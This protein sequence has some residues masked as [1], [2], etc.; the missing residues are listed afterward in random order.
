MR[1]ERELERYERL[2]DPA[3]VLA[4]SG[5]FAIILTL[6]VLEIHVPDLARGQS[7][8]EAIAEVRPSFVAFLISFVVVAISW[9]GHRDLFAHIRRTDRNLVWLNVV[10]LLPLSLLPFG[11]ALLSQYQQEAVALRMYG[12]LLLLIALTRLVVWLYAV[13]RPHL[14]H[15]AISQRTRTAG[16]IIAGVPAVY[17]V[18]ILLA[19]GSPEASLAIYAGAPILYFI[20]LFLERSTAPPGSEENDFT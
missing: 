8:R 14:L 5:V 16:A 17:T 11:A 19:P 20:G 2:H 13:N 6:L 7:L 10:Y 1:Q 3:R 4:L 12:L 15:E 9:A 18:A